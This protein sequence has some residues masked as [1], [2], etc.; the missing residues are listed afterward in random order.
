LPFFDTQGVSVPCATPLDGKQTMST[1]CLAIG[2][3]TAPP[4]RRADELRVA[5]LSVIFVISGFCG[6]IYESIWSH[7]LKLFVGHSAYAQTIVLIV[8]IG[9]MAVGAGLVGRAAKRIRQPLFVYAAVECAIGVVSLVFHQVFVVVTDWGYGTLLP[10]ACVPES[11]CLAQ[12]ALASA[13]ILPQSVLL[14]TTFPLMTAGVLRLAPSN[15]GSRIA[16]FYFLNSIGAVAGVLASAFVLIPAM[17]LPGA[18]LT[19]GLLNVAVGIGA[20]ACGKGIANS[21]AAATAA[22]PVTDSLPYRRLLLI[23]AALTGLSSFIYEIA[24]IRMLSLVVGASTDAFELM[25]AAFILGLALGGL[26]VRKRIDHFKDLLASLAIVQ[27]LMGIAAAL[28]LP[29][30]DWTFDLLAWLL[31]GLGRSEQSYVL[32]NFVSHGI[33]LVVMLPATF[34][35]G[36]TLPL[37]T[38]AL[39]QGRQGE[40]AIGFVY[41]ANTLGAI[42]GVIIAVHVALPLLGLK[43]ALLLGA[44]VDVALAALLLFGN[45]AMQRRQAFGW[46]AVGV[47]SLFA[48]AVLVPISVERM[49]SGVYRH[50]MPALLANFEVVFHKVGKTANVDVLKSDDSISIR[51]NGKSDASIARNS[52]APSADEYTMALAAVL[53]LVYRP[54]IQHAAVIG[55]GSGMT[56]A[57]LLGSS[58]LQRIDTIEIEPAMVEGARLFG[59][60]IGPAY[61]DPRS[62]VV[63]DDAKSYFARSAHRYDLIISEPS[64]PWVSGVA[65]LFTSEFYQRVKRQLA[66]DGLFVQWIQT[67][68]FSDPLLATI[69]RALDG[70][71]A[72]YAVYQAN[73]GDMIIVAGNGPLPAPRGDFTQFRALR[74]T[75][76]RLGMGSLQDIE[77]RRL[78]G[79]AS[80]RALL[81]QMMPAANS[82]YYPLVDLGAPRA[83]FIGAHALALIRLPMAPVPVIEMLERRSA[84]IPHDI[85][86][87]KA[88]VERREA[89]QVARASAEWLQGATTSDPKAVLPN[90]IGILRSALWNCAP[91]PPRVTLAEAMRSVAAFVN[92]HLPP[93]DA[94]RVW[95]GIRGAPCAR[96]LTVQDFAW[97]ELFEAVGA[98]DSTRMARIGGRLASSPEEVR[99]ELRGYAVLAGA[100]GLIATGRTAEAGAFM[101]EQAQRLPKGTMNESVFQ[102]LRGHAAGGFDGRAQVAGVTPVAG[103][104]Y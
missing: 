63:I 31:M 70:E 94:A 71:F 65:S 83:R 47:A 30:Y 43:G 89:I 87:V 102:V 1:Q 40:R 75:L 59:D 72:D 68:E 27:V 51:T 45:H 99:A 14:G 101:K 12:W 77:A 16:L 36:M 17:G 33:A 28:T 98:R 69:L 29:I 88:F 92:P 44:G 81:G 74:P 60:M 15:P 41:A 80:V 23:V 4:A 32:Y 79:A 48:V 37:I 96:Q 58:N 42:A 104:T 85:A 103:V 9:G 38:T 8:F 84:A 67:Y 100:T 90:D 10:A 56:T 54:G 13:L 11:P 93:M 6:L 20:Y 50:G 34:L 46:L 62:R 19:A 78:A 57:T 64:N 82:D 39:L 55:F 7:Y 49:A 2:A 61:T 73:G 95:S 25:L 97:L 66:E 24:W 91:L 21:G 18:L 86:P 35:A 5:A 22:A 52:A 76:D 3:A 53:P 26:W